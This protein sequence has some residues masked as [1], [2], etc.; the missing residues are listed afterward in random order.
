MSYE[1]EEKQKATGTNHF[2]E[3]LKTIPMGNYDTIRHRIINDCMITNQIFNHWKCGNSKV[4]PL[5]Q[6][7]INLIAGKN[8]FAENYGSNTAPK[9]T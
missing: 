1:L 7:E 9:E 3:W 2:S 6:K 5:A 8:I 4:P